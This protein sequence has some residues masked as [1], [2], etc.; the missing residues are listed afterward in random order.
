VEQSGETQSGGIE[1]VLKLKATLLTTSLLCVL[2]MPFTGVAQKTTT[3]DA[4]DVTAAD[5][6]KDE[7]PAP[8]PNC[9]G[10]FWTRSTLSAVPI[11][12]RLATILG[13]RLK[14]VF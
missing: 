8:S 11:L 7:S 2:V 5:S 10:D 4:A 12:L 14:M 9:S 6:K 3:R 1:K 13:M